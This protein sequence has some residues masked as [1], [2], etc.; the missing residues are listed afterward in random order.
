MN[1]MNEQELPNLRGVGDRLIADVALH[2]PDEISCL[3]F[4]TDGSNCCL[5]D[6]QSLNRRG[7]NLTART[8]KK[9]KAPTVVCQPAL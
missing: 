9:N 5:S 2:V 6:S 4:P 7:I 1:R 8:Y 3:V